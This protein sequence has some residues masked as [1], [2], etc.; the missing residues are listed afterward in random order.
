MPQHDCVLILSPE[1]TG[2][3]RVQ[4]EFSTG[5]TEGQAGVHRHNF[6]EVVVDEIV[7]EEVFCRSLR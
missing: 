4:F 3:I 6:R 7:D 5:G 2:K 1:I